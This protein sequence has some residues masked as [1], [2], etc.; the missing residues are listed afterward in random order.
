MAERKQ[1][2]VPYNPSQFSGEEMCKWYSNGLY[3]PNVPYEGKWAATEV[4]A[5]NPDDHLHDQVDPN[6]YQPCVP[7]SVAPDYLIPFVNKLLYM[8]SAGVKCGKIKE[9]AYRGSVKHPWSKMQTEDGD[10]KPFACTEADYLHKKS[11]VRWSNMVVVSFA[12]HFVFPSYGFYV[13]VSLYDD[14]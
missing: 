2:V 6:V 4:K 12:N 9:I 5:S 7:H 1:A 10:I 8:E 11:G 14:F 3:F 13:F